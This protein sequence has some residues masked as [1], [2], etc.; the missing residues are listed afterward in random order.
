MTFRIN[1]DSLS[2]K[3]YF[4]E[5]SRE[6][7]R[8]L[9]TL[10]SLGGEVVSEDDLAGLAGVSPARCRASLVLFTESGIIA[11]GDD[12]LIDEFPE[13]RV[14]IVEKIRK[15]PDAYP[16]RYAKISAKPL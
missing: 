11:E 10:V 6:E 9:L 12:V 2:S 14:V 13:R 1:L 15:T 4:Q 7:L 5:A 8:V 16:R 3:E